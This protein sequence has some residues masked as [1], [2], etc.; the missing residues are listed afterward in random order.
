MEGS[1]VEVRSRR[2]CTRLTLPKISPISELAHSPACPAMHVATLADPAFWTIVRD[3][4]AKTTGAWK[5]GREVCVKRENFHMPPNGLA[6][7]RGF[8]WQFQKSGVA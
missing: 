1:V 8:C 4:E 3:L 5:E 7:V 2:A 6:D